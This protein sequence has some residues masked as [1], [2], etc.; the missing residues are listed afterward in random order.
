MN[1]AIRLI[2]Y[3]LPLLFALTLFSTTHSS[4]V[5]AQVLKRG[6]QGGVVGAVIGGIVDGGRG[7]GKGA[8]IGAGVGVVAGAIEAENKARRSVYR[9]S[10]PRSRRAHRHSTPRSGLVY[11]TQ[12]ALE[13][14]GYSPGPLDGVYGPGTAGAIRQYED[15]NQMPVTGRPSRQ[16]LDHLRYG[17]QD[18]ADHEARADPQKHA[19]DGSQP[20]NPASALGQ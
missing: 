10:R 13:Y 14:L 6:I 18:P 1:P 2:R 12:V 17:D 16:L 11:D 7:V 5:S 3:T 8:A 15:D 20:H 4:T 19:V 9:Y